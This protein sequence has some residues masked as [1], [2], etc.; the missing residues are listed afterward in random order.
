M[1][2]VPLPAET[3]SNKNSH[4]TNIK[5]EILHVL[6]QEAKAIENVTKKLPQNTELLVEK[7]VKTKGK[8]AFSG[9]GKSGHVAKKLVANPY[10]DLG[11]GLLEC[12]QEIHKE[13]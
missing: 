7:I 12:I 4:N 5:K 9:C 2:K 1:Q 11:Q 6:S 8:I 13:L 3:T 10:I